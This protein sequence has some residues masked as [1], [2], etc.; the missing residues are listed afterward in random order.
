MEKLI[1]NI[2]IGGLNYKLKYQEN[3]ARDYNMLGSHC[4]NTSEIII[5]TGL[6]KDR[7]EKTIIHEILEA[8]NFE[9][10]LELSHDKIT[11]LETTLYAILKDNKELFKLIIS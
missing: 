2:K 1:E 9:Y 6:A 7:T 5:D 8:I 10:E 11:V 3:Y 4:G